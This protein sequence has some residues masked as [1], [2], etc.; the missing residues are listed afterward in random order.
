MWAFLSSIL[1]DTASG[2]VPDRID[3]PSLTSARVRWDRAGTIL[4]F[5]E[6]LRQTIREKPSSGLVNASASERSL[7]PAPWLTSRLIDYS[8]LRRCN[9]NGC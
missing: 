7:S 4:N 3:P 9:L 2:H 6:E 5:R 8:W 1:N